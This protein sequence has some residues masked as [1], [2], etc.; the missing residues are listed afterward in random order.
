MN[1][2]LAQKNSRTVFKLLLVVIGMGGF[3][4]ALIPLY[5]VFS[6]MTGINGKLEATTDAE[7]LNFEI[8]LQRTVNI[9]FITSLGKATPFIFQVATKKLQVHPGQFYEVH[10][11]AQNTANTAVI[12]RA[13][14]SVAPGTVAANFKLVDCYC[15][16]VQRFEAGEKKQLQLR[17]VVDPKLPQTSNNI[18]LAITFLNTDKN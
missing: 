17:F 9:D 13:V 16:S 12:A 4:V 5:D 1:Q 8:D 7:S 15:F 11:S 6:A 10:Y 18:A 3:G 14:P 2:N